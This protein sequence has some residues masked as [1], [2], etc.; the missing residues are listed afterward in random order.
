MVSI[1]LRAVSFMLIAF[2]A[3]ITPIYASQAGTGNA[4]A[5]NISHDEVTLNWL[6]DWFSNF[7]AGFSGW[8]S[9][10]FRGFYHHNTTST[11][12]RTSLT[13]VP[14]TTAASSTTISQTTSAK[15]TI[16]TVQT[17]HATSV[18]SAQTTGATTSIVTISSSTANST[19]SSSSTTSIPSNQVYA[20]TL[21]KSGD[22][23]TWAAEPAASYYKGAI[24]NMPRNASGRMTTYI[25]LSNVTSWTPSPSPGNLL[26]YGVAAVNA[27]GTVQWSTNEE[28][29]VWPGSS[30]TSSTTSSSTTTSVAS[31]TT[32]KTTTTA[33]SSSTTAPTTTS[34]SI[35]TS[36]ST[37][38]TTTVQNQ[39]Y[40]PTLNIS[41]HTI[42]WAAESAAMYYGGAIS[43][44]PRNTNRSTTYLN[45]SK[46]TSWTPPAAC[47]QTLYYGVSAVGTNGGQWSTNEVS[48]TWPACTTTSTS[49]TTKA[50]TSSTTSSSTISSTTMSSSTTTSSQLYSPT[51]SISGHTIT[52]AA[53]SAASYYGGAISNGPRNDTSRTTTY[54][55]LS[56]ATSWT[57]PTACGTLYYGVSA[58]GSAGTDWS[59]NEVSIAWPACSSTSTTSAQSTTTVQGSTTTI[60]GS[61]GMM[62]GMNGGW[63][64]VHAQDMSGTGENIVRID[65]QG[66]QGT[67]F[68]ST[69]YQ[70]GVKTDAL[71]A[72]PYDKGGV[73]GLAGCNSNGNSCTNATNWANTALNWYE[74]NCTAG[75]SECPTVEVLNE[76]YG[77]WYFGSGADSSQN[78]VAYA[79]LVEATYNVFHAKYGS[80]SPLIIAAWEPCSNGASGNCYTS[81][82]TGFKSVSGISSHYD[83]ITV[84]P[85]GGGCGYST[86]LSGQGNRA[87]VA[88][89]H[90]N[91]GK[92]VYVTEVGWPTATVVESCESSGD[93]LQWSLTGQA[94][95]IYNFVTWA[96][97]TGYVSMITL[98]GY[99][100]YGTY[101]WYGIEC[102]IYA[103]T[104]SSYPAGSGSCGT[105]PDAWKKPGWYALQEAANQQSCTVC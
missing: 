38:S 92:N 44:G 66:A 69:Y 11:T 19:I 84:H 53:E 83:G 61:T 89:A 2:S 49:S 75:A 91:T 87:A 85:Y 93:S 51:L 58:V 35:S 17:T 52:W 86:T 79:N 20:P 15:T 60:S 74:G 39:V 25:N 26:Y 48:I 41:G 96:R 101:A 100:D 5:A 6:S 30:T 102:S 37:S 71:F 43:N 65:A 29:I 7:W 9:N 103:T 31:T 94:D 97:S 62:V 14:I 98:F 78:G 54:L 4:N 10:L 67:E 68:P 59:T 24:S 36:T 104:P 73:I 72:G 95:N 12:L 33:I 32:S 105:N 3:I 40:A 77:D 55:N 34:T 16:T 21:N 50:T 64:T 70:Y 8:W 22:T 18:T 63:G 1:N 13:T 81:W 88:S 56:H 45:L 90:N 46:A 28:E 23:I 47:G 99:R 82:W 27:S 42:T 57:P 80:N 76:P